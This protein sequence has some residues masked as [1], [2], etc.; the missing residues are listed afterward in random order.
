MT[1]TVRR[2]KFSLYIGYFLKT[3]L[4]LLLILPNV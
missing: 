1:Y 3:A 2:S 4:K